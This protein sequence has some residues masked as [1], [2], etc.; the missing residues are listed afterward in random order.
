MKKLGVI[1]IIDSLNTGGAEVLAVNIAN[2]LIEKNV[3][4]HICVTRTEGDLIENINK[5]VGYLF[6]EKKKK[7][8]LRVILKL[9]K[10]LKLNNI[11]IIHAHSTSYFIAFCVK[12]LYPNIKII[13]HDHY[14]SS[15]NLAKR[16]LFPIK[17]VSFFFELTISVN[18]DLK[19][20]AENNLL[21]SNVIFLNNFPL[22]VK[23]EVK[24]ILKGENHR[25]IV[26]LAAFR[27]QKDHE[28]LIN[29]FELFM[30]NNKQWTLHLVGRVKKDSYSKKI[31][32]LIK[33]KGLQNHIFVYGSCLDISNI[34][35][36]STIGVLSSKSEGLPISLLEYGLAK[37]PVIVTDVGECANVV[38]DNKSG[39]VVKPK[40]F[41]ELSEKLEILSNSKDKRKELREQHQKNILKNYSKEVFLDKLITLYNS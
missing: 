20:W 28:N 17:Y 18:S 33:Q 24:T 14:G 9:K 2:S 34:L 7:I 21:C 19:K 37:L 29:A 10:Y 11:S 35:Q 40:N 41:V 13:W 38:F 3:K 27:D 23:T 26:H 39:L 4:S 30:V 8:D 5:N 12:L 31:L 32:K 6:L 16:P 36:Q 15:Q 22:F 1:Q 25:R